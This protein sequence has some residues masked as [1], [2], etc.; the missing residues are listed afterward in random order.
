MNSQQYMQRCLD[1]ATLGQS[2]VAP[3]PMV[4]CVI[5]KNDTIIGEGYH[6]LFGGPH[7]EVVAIQSV[8]DQNELI[9]ATVYVSLEPCAH[10]GKT[11]PCSNLLIDKKV[12]K[13]VVACLD[14][15]PKVAGKGIERLKKAGIAVE[16]GLLENEAQQLNKRFFCYHQ[17]QRPYVILKWA[18]TKDGFLD[19][20]RTKDQKG[21]HWISSEESKALVHHWRS[22]EMSILVGKH[23]AI[24]DNPSLTVRDVSGKN[25][26]RILIDSQLQVQN[27]ISLFSKDAPTLIFNRLKN[28]KNDS[29]EWIKIAETN[30]KN[31][32]EELH[33]RGI[34]SVMVEGGSRTLQ[35]FIVD[36]V[37]DEAYVLVGDV[38]F[39]EGVK[40][41][42]L[43]RIPDKSHPFGS[44]Q[45]YYF[46]RRM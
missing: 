23:T 26:I 30:T 22:Q 11:P 5:V 46:K 19:R 8:K 15:N 24:N 33:K 43:N 35:Y 40:A 36:N 9:G 14:P 13:V 18:Q 16:I 38:T 25:P 6:A 41:P 1:L 12:S 44:D 34:H 28:D 31:I 37:W 27:D 45:I 17:K 20:L 29:V 42:V 32:L 3:N 10:F 2:E 39:K 4:G 21:I 7:A